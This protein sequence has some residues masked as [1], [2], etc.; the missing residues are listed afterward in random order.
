MTST[1]VNKAEVID[2]KCVVHYTDK[3]G[4]G[5]IE[6]DVVLSAAGVTANIENIG[7][8]ELGVKT[9]YGKIIVDEYYRTNIEGCFCNRRCYSRSGISPRGISRS[10]LLC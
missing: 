9:E 8:E 1:A 3:K 6:C 5:S 4:E 7:L 10:N 2:N